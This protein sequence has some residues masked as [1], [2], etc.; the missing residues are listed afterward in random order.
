M[1]A[2]PGELLAIALEEGLHLPVAEAA[3]QLGVSRQQLHRVLSKQS[4]MTA[5]MALRLGRL[6]G[7]CPRIWLALQ[8]DW[9]IA[10]ARQQL[11]A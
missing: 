4:G 5:E 9:D 11:G 8:A 10:K 3:R 2:H 1:V 6:C 7:K